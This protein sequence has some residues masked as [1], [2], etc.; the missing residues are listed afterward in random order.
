MSFGHALYYP[1]INLT[2]K[3]WLK[4]SFLFWDKLSRIVPSTVEPTDSEDIVRF[5]YETDFINDYSPDKWVISETFNN[6]SNFLIEFQESGRFEKHYKYKHP[7]NRSR[8]K[9]DQFKNNSNYRREILRDIAINKGSYIHLQKLDNRLKEL[10][11]EIGLAVPG[12]NE[13]ENWIK[14]DNDIGFIYMSYLA[15]VIS[16]EKTLPLV[17]DVESS[18][19]ESTAFEPE[20]FRDYGSEFE[21]KLGNILLTTFVP[22]NINSIPFEKLIQIREKYSDQR[23]EFFNTISQ[24]CQ[25][26]PSIDNKSALEDALNHH[27]KS[28]IDQTSNLKSAYESNKIETV[29]KFMAISVPTTMVSLSTF[30]PV[31]YKP[32]GIAAGLLFGLGS[33]VN[34]IKQNRSK[35]QQHPLSYLL[36]VDSELSGAGLMR[37]INDGMKGI[38]RF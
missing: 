38:R 37:K 18:Y 31:E 33:S 13:W 10:L 1:H 4:H 36:S 12:E 34:S 7:D 25:D 16:K 29:S 21:H 3:N 5:R 2:N 22:K 27:S 23:T 24:L 15:K 8:E 19:S 26:I 11:F 35:L 6:F 32:F 14:I 28:L 30:V 20:I 17:T 9:Y